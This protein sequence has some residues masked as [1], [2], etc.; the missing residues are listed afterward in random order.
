MLLGEAVV[1]WCALLFVNWLPGEAIGSLA[2]GRSRIKSSR[3][4]PFVNRLADLRS[5]PRPCA[6]FNKPKGC[7]HGANCSYRHDASLPPRTEQ[8]RGPKRINKLDGGIVNMN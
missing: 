3:V 4:R 2:C 6:F 7:R 1:S 5:I 8:P